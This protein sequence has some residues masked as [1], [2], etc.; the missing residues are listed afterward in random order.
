LA[1][2][3]SAAFK[4]A[5]LALAFAGAH[6]R[7]AHLAHHGAHVGK[8]EVDEARHDH[9]VGDAAHA[10]LQHLVRHQERFLEGGVGVGDQEQVLVGNDDQRIDMLLQ[11]LDPRLGG[12]GAARALE[13][14]RL[15]D[16]A[17]GEDALLA[18]GLGDDRGRAGAGAAAHAGGDEHHVRAF[19]DASIRLSVSSAAARPISGREPAPRPFGDARSEL[20]TTLGGRGIQRLRVGIGDDEIDALDLRVDHVGDGVTACAA[21][22]DH[23]DARLQ[24]IH[25]RRSNFDAHMFAP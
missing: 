1:I 11:L 17:D 13:R 15:G 2:A 24:F 22:A 18:R 16:D 9:Q 3:F 19:Q 14:E 10:L 25:E 4:R 23:A 21:H 7:L 20:D 5:V 12:A 8:V 6:H